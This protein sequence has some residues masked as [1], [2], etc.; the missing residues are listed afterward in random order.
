MAKS[1]EYDAALSELLDDIPSDGEA[2]SQLY[3]AKQM[4]Y[5]A[6]RTARRRIR[7]RPAN[8]VIEKHRWAMHALRGIRLGNEWMVADAVSCYEEL[9]DHVNM[10]NLVESLTDSLCALVSMLY[11]QLLD[12]DFAGVGA[13]PPGNVHRLRLE[14]RVQQRRDFWKQFRRRTWVVGILDDDGNPF[15]TEAESARALESYWG[16]IF[17]EKED[18]L[19]L[20]DQVLPHV[21]KFPENM[22]MR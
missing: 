12:E 15:Q 11:N 6:M 13:L 22:E 7:L 5:I 1:P 19:R 4:M 21:Q 20:W 9:E 10:D 2:A 18:D 17:G 8:S 16:K 14:R 3:E